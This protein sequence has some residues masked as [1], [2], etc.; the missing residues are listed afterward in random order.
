MK[1]QSKNEAD[2][3]VFI[4]KIHEQLVLLDKKVDMLI[5]KTM[6]PKPAEVKPFAAQKPFQLQSNAHAQ[7]QRQNERFRERVM[8]K[9]ICADCRK[10]C[11]V[12]FQP[13]GN[14][15]VY[16]QECFSRRKNATGNSFNANINSRPR[17]TPPIHAASIAK[18]QAIEKKKSATKK[19]P[20]AKNKKGK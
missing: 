4:A 15:P 10:Q 13:S 3:L 6:A 11:E 7:A 8:Y 2:I 9:V 20:V 12:P 19:K 14:R 5:S 17:Q 16:C 1:K 18:P